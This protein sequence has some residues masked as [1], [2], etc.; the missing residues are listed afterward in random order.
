MC[1]SVSGS[2]TKEAECRTSPWIFNLTVHISADCI[3]LAP[4]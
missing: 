2:C 3:Y 4:Q 1:G